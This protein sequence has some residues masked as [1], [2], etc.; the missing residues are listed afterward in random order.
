MLKSSNILKKIKTC[1][2]IV[3]FFGLMVCLGGCGNKQL[4]CRGTCS[5]E[6]G[7]RPLNQIGVNNQK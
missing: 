2:F 6:S 1:I 3:P 4:V 7:M 5:I